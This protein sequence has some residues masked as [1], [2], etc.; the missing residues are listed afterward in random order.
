MEMSEEIFTQTIFPPVK[1]S[2][3]KTFN[4]NLSDTTKK[5]DDELIHEIYCGLQMNW[6]SM[7]ECIDCKNNTRTL[8]QI[9]E[10]EVG[11]WNDTIG[12]I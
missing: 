6:V 11:C 3:V 9:L 8:E 1:Q 4:F 12:E 2:S 7:V 10:D 5:D